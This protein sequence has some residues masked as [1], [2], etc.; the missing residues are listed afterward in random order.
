MADKEPSSSNQE[1]GCESTANDSSFCA[2]EQNSSA[3]LAPWAELA[4]G[5]QGI[6]QS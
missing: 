6:L 2:A 1:Q 4:T 5:I 3:G